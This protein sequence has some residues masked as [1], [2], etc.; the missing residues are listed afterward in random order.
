M[1]TN[2]PKRRI[3][4]YYHVEDGVV[5]LNKKTVNGV[6]YNEEKFLAECAALEALLAQHRERVRAEGGQWPPQPSRYQFDERE[7]ASEQIHLPKK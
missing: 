1:N 5:H 2:H 6:P 4:D 7:G 3:T